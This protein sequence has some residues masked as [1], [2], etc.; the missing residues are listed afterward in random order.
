MSC[1]E[2]RVLLHGMLDRELDL[3][4]AVRLETHMQACH[5]CKAEYRRQSAL[6]AATRRLQG[7]YRAPR[8]L[9]AR[10]SASI[11]MQE[12]LS[13]RAPWWRGAVTGWM[14]T[15]VSLALAASLLFVVGIPGEQAIQ[16]ELISGHVR[17]L[18]A[19]H[20]TDVTTSDQ[21]TVKPW[22]NGKLDASPPVVDLASQG[23]PLVG[24]R[25][26]YIHNH[27]VGALVFKHDQHV[28]N[29]FI[30]PVADANDGGPASATRDGFN[31]LHW[32]CSGMTFWAV[33]D[34]NPAAL[35]RFEAE[36]DRQTNGSSQS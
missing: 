30:W 5:D 17:S 27:V 10:V 15:G 26:D 21:H 13:C 29:L 4:D 11:R 20:L 9:R 1:A 7:K 12:H 8:G 3:A 22:F 28:I 19:S 23:F 33:S 14:G 32:T 35:R 34:V 25:L 36:Y 6:A 24:G 31:L 16:Q 2:M 18:L